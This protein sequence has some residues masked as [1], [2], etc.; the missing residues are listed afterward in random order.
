[1]EQVLS[2]HPLSIRVY[3]DGI[4]QTMFGFPRSWND[5]GGASITN[6][7]YPSPR[8]LSAPLGPIALEGTSSGQS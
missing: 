6:P 1:M 5:V 2:V 7:A 4:E 8:R 3:A